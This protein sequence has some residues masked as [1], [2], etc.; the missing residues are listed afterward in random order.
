M[1]TRIRKS[2]APRKDQETRLTVSSVEIRSLLDAALHD[3]TINRHAS[4]YHFR[5]EYDQRKG[6]GSLDAL[7]A[8]GPHT[9]KTE[10]IKEGFVQGKEIPL[11]A[12]LAETLPL[13]A[14]TP[15]RLGEYVQAKVTKTAKPDDQGGSF[16]DLIVEIENSW[17]AEAAPKEFQDIPRK[18]SFLIDVTVFGSS[19]D[20]KISSLRNNL[21]L[22]GQKAKVLCYE[23][24]LGAL[25]IERPKIIVAKTQEY[26]EQVGAK[27]GPCVTQLASD[28]FAI[29]S[30]KGFDKAYRDYFLDFMTA[31]AENAQANADYID[32]LSHDNERRAKLRA[33]YLKIV[34]FVEAYKKTPADR[35]RAGVSN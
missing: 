1:L 23:D 28:K 32:T 11:I 34:H 8:Q 18:M 6:K 17:I 35:P 31:I 4:Y 16:I 30:T 7:I 29:N 5:D 12:Q 24:S 3:A 27:L 19:Y 22:Y 10:Q 21:L 20:N 15:G 26:M 2:D 9:Q 14:N 33:E 25:G 13:Y